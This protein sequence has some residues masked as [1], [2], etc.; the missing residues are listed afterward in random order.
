LVSK[1]QLFVGDYR[2]TFIYR[3]SAASL[4][5]KRAGVTATK[6]ATPELQLTN[7]NFWKVKGQ[8][9]V[10]ATSMLE[11]VFLFY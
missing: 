8:A 10:L 7:Y 9:Q 2:L 11:Q 3:I 4:T 1:L 6:I 5:L